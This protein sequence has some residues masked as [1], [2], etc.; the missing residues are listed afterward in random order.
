M[1]D[2]WDEESGTSSGQRVAL[3]RAGDRFRLDAH[4]Q[5]CDEHISF[6]KQVAVFDAALRWRQ[7]LAPCIRHTF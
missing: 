2:G 3:L 7:S 6:S 5:Q 1:E 4:C